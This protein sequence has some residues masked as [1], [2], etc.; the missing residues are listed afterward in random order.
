MCNHDL[1][2]MSALALRCCMPSCSC[3]HIRQIT[4]AHVTYITCHPLKQAPIISLFIK[5]FCVRKQLD[6]DNI[7]C[8]KNTVSF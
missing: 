2:D 7:D 5:E 6:W 4:P 8:V 1:P 3:V